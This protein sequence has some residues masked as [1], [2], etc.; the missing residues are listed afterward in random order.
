MSQLIEP[1]TLRGFRDFLPEVML[2]RE[3][4]ME[5]ARR[6][7]RSYGFSPI[8]TP[9]LEYAEILTGKGGEES[10]KQL[11]RFKDGGDRDVAMRF[12]LTVPLA[13]FA[14]Q[15]SS[16]LGTPF[17]R[18]H[19]APVWRG[20]NTQ[21]GRYREFVQCDFDTIGTDSNA[22]DI[23]T[24]LVIHDLLVALGFERFT[25]RVNN[26][27]ILNG[28]LAALGLTDKT[29]GVLRAI[30]KLPKIGQDN[31]IAEMVEKVGTTP[32]QAKQVLL[33]V[34]P[35]TDLAFL[36]TTY[37]DNEQVM[38]GV[39]RL[40]QL[41]DAAATAGIPQDRIALDVSIARGLD[42]YTGTIYETFLTDLPSIGSI[43]SGGRY[44]NLAGLFT[45]ERLPGVG[46]SLG[47]DRLI[48]AMEE[49]KLLGTQTTPA[50]VLITQFD[51]ERLGDY[52]RVAR[53]L[54]AAGISTEVYPET[55]KLGKQ[56]QYADKKGFRV[57]LIAGS[58]E[59]AKGVW[60]IKDLKAGTS[61]TVEEGNLIASL[62]SI[63]SAT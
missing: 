5:T 13:R 62:Q 35:Q 55:K 28:V 47:L 61:T 44:D 46:A 22:A 60:Q 19:I 18:Y 50:P 56:L 33:T 8:D 63:L 53:L 26:R 4:L 59:F 20:E 34:G 11:F 17:K 40:R 12:D 9:A 39:K 31:V 14:A 49:L 21:R 10:D 25:I 24:L 48:A 29:V 42:Y 16:T 23:E 41:F 3:R 1:R 32:D 54:R 43:C 45:K 52:L 30:D 6:V 38:Q 57:A 37:A 58:D 36:A 27:L 2:V 15:H 7:F 51:D